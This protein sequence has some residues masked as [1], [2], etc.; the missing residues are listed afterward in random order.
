M[1]IRPPQLQFFKDGIKI[2]ATD[3]NYY[4]KEIKV[5][6]SIKEVYKWQ[7]LNGKNFEQK[8]SQ[9]LR[10]SYTIGWAW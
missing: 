3:T 2:T 8:K 10:A 6:I 5:T 7:K 9:L 1:L 4:Q